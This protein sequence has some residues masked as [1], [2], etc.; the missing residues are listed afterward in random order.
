MFF[1]HTNGEL[2]KMIVCLTILPNFPRFFEENDPSPLDDPVALDIIFRIGQIYLRD[3]LFF[4]YNLYKTNP[5][6]FFITNA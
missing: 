5:F 4:L 2:F 3:E 6:N 1:V